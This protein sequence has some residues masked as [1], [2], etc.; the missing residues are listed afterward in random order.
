MH[1]LGHTRSTNQRDHLLHTPDTFVRT[2]LPGMEL[3]S[4]IVHISPQQA[5]PSPS[6]QQSSN[7]AAS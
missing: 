3:A 2:V 7:P 6:T 5:R 1:K 4:A